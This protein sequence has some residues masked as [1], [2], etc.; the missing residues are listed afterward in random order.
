ML[1]VSLRE[2][3]YLLIGEN[4]RISYEDMKSK[5]HLVLGI[6]A[7]KEVSVLRGKVYEENLAKMASEGDEDACMQYK[8]LKREYVERERKRHIR[9]ARHERQE[10]RIAAGEIKSYSS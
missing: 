4:V 6:E 3:D 5:D 8:K 10:L 7:P 2:G 1:L 9:R